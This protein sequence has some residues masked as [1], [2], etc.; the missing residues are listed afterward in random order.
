[1]LKLTIV[2]L[3]V[4]SAAALPR[5]QRKVPGG[6]RIVGGE[7]ATE[8]QFPYQLS[9]QWFGSHICGAAIIGPDLAITAAHCVEGESAS[10]IRVIAGKHRRVA[11][12]GHEQPRSVQRIVV[13]AD[14]NGNTFVNDI[15]LLH[16]SGESFTDTDWVGA[17]ALPTSMQQTTGDIIVS[18]WGTTSS[19]GQLANILQWVQ[20]PTI[21]DADC[22]EMYPEETIAPSMLCAGLTQGGQDS[23]QGDSGGPLA[24]VDGGYLAGLV[25]WGYGCALPRRPGVNTEVSYFI[26]WIEM[27][28]H[29]ISV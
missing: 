24:A 13:H 26:D 23:C 17:I 9:M 11:D 7:D 27:N 19:G 1:M 16:L 29:S 10:S 14:Y 6:G 21:N 15:A 28:R 22:Q 18:G 8:G 12:S 4:A 3:L 5:V 25:S 20:I 2:A